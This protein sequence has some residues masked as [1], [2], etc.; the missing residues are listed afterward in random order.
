VSTI[1]DEQGTPVGMS[2]IT[3]DITPIKEAEK[4][5]ARLSA[6]VEFSQDAIIG[7]NLDGTIT[8]WNNGAERV[9]G[10]AADEIIGQSIETLWFRPPP[11][12]L[13]LIQDKLLAKTYYE[14]LDTYHRRNDGTVFPVSFIT[15][16]VFDVEKNVIGASTIAHD[17]TVQKEIEADLRN[18]TKRLKLSNKALEEFAYIASHDLQ[19][20]LR[21]V[22]AFGD[23]LVSRYNHVLD[24]TGQD[25]LRR[26]QEAAERMRNLITDLLTYSRLSSSGKS[27]ASI[28]LGE[29]IREVMV[30]FET[31]LEK[32]QGQVIVG[33]LT[34]VEAD[35]LQMRQLF[36]NLISNS[37]KY[38]HPDMP[39]VVE[40][41]G[42]HISFVPGAEP[43]YRII[44]KDNGIGFDNK[45]SER[46]FEL[47]QRLHSHSEYEG[48]GIGLAI[49]RKIIDQHSGSIEATGVPGEGA[50]F[51]IIL[52]LKYKGIPDL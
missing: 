15:S 40:I 23:R 24:E 17:I 39:P 48:T 14:R 52:P 5:R 35:A 7:H 29:I 45:Y 21:K 1:K 44:V 2:G 11:N 32:T 18:F 6:I 36:Q 25:Y 34:C 3:I 16:P 42:E 8:S 9:Y 37:L 38:S 22:Q 4:I 10:F 20:P 47:F 43:S 51:A 30:D 49:C 33:T 31:R 50:T 13:Q 41:T 26:M 19:E 28:D 27:F 12:K 46:I